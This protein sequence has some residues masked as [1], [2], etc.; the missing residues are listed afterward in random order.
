MYFLL[1]FN[2]L[3]NSI[4]NAITYNGRIMNILISNDDGIEADGI[5]TLAKAL[6]NIANVTVA[7]PLYER[8]GASQSL[9]IHQPMQVKEVVRNGEFL[10]YGINGSPADCVKLA[11]AHI[12]SNRPD[13]IVSGI[14]KGPNNATNIHYSGTVGA[15]A[16][17]A[18]NGIMSFAVSLTGYHHQDYT[19]SADFMKDFMQKAHLI[20]K[21]S[22]LYNINIPPL[23]KDEI[24][25]IRWTRA[26]QSPYLINYDKG[27]DPFGE[28]FYW[29]SDFR[30]P[31]HI[32]KWTDDGALSENY[33]SITPLLMDRTDYNTL[34]QIRKLGDIW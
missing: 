30:Q 33:I 1:S 31:E 2:R 20:P 27:I 11:L 17:G 3:Q 12:C 13:F 24:N 26:S 34:E 28:D 19:V 23:K 6:K 22:L 29:L 9:T 16:E 21:T 5:Q 15:A 7:A 18:I 8:S 14:N 4:N 10:G 32:D 25:G